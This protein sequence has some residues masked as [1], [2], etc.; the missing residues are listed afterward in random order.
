MTLGGITGEIARLEHTLAAV[1][2]EHTPGRGANPFNLDVPFMEKSLVLLRA[3]RDLMEDRP[4]D[5]VSY[6]FE[7]DLAQTDPVVS[8]MRAEMMTPSAEMPKCR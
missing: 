6:I 3:Y 2:F 1:S 5:L 8:A 7:R 4:N